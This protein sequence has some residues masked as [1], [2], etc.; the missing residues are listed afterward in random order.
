[1]MRIII[2]AI[3]SFVISFNAYAASPQLKPVMKKTPA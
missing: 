1:M 2:L 3:I